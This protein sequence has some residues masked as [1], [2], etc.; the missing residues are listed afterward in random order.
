MK[1]SLLFGAVVGLVLFG[2]A[3]A[4]A[5]FAPLKLKVKM[6]AESQDL[7]H[8][9]VRDSTIFKSTTTRIRVTSKDVLNLAGVA[10]GA[11]FTNY[12][13]AVDYDTGNFMVLDPA[14]SVMANLTQAGF[15]DNFR[16]GESDYV[17]TGVCDHEPFY[18]ERYTFRRAGSMSFTDAANGNNF[19]LTG[20]KTDRHVHHH[21]GDYSYTSSVTLT[22]QGTGELGWEFMLLSGNAAGKVKY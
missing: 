13:L 10:Y 11:N 5:Q 4:N 17:R 14:G 18:T 19:T 16:T 22:G 12:S 7:S 9:Q 2:V 3:S 20:I 21:Y 6:V 8:S 15:M 1:T